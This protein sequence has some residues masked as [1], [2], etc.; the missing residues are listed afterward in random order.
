MENVVVTP[1][2][3]SQSS[4]F[5]INLVATGRVATSFTKVVGQDHLNIDVSSQVVWG[6]KKLELALA[7]DN[8]GSM[9]SAN[10]MAELK[11]AAKELI[12]TLKK[13]S[14]NDDDIRISIVPFAQEVNVG[15]TNVNA[16]G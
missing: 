13:V 14:Q 9:A 15:T 10:K 4:G 5:K 16:T 11:K 7:L 1:T 12:Q 3:T 2:F 6:M 8:T